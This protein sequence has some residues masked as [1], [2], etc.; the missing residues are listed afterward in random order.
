MALFKDYGR[1]GMASEAKRS[2]RP[3]NHC[4]LKSP[5]P[6]ASSVSAASVDGTAGSGKTPVCFQKWHRKILSPAKP[7]AVPRCP[8]PSETTARKRLFSSDVAAGDFFEE[9]DDQEMVLAASQAEEK[10]LKGEGGTKKGARRGQHRQGTEESNQQAGDGQAE[11]EKERGKGNV[12]EGQVGLEERRRRSRSRRQSPA[13]PERREEGRKAWRQEGRR[14]GAEAAER[15]GPGRKRR[16][17]AGR[18][19]AGDQGD[20]GPARRRRDESGR[21]EAA[22]GG[23][24][25]R[26]WARGAAGRYSRRH[27]GGNR[28]NVSGMVGG[29]PRVAPAP[30]IARQRGRHLRPAAAGGWRRPGVAAGCPCCLARYVLSMSGL[31]P[32]CGNEQGPSGQSD[33]VVQEDAL[34][35]RPPQK[36]G[37]QEAGGRHEPRVTRHQATRSH[38]QRPPQR[39]RGRRR[40]GGWEYERRGFFLSGPLYR[41]EGVF[42]RGANASAGGPQTRQRT[43]IARAARGGGSAKRAGRPAVQACVDSMGYYG[44]AAYEKEWRGGRG[45]AQ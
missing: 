35:E 38:R 15:P 8:P 41:A 23:S 18:N 28:T 32:H 42:R 9:Q 19:R 29:A 17:T 16:G 21:G 37:S 40:L 39:A 24:G 45:D 7:S 20:A 30:E 43:P 22:A 44:A 1:K 25:G 5:P 4:S 11:G 27:D 34:G 26:S 36:T 33:W 2:P 31:R 14:G 6:A 10:L 12:G 3:P 13:A